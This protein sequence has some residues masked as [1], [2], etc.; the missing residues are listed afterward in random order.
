VIKLSIIARKTSPE[1][2]IY[3]PVYT[4]PPKNRSWRI[5]I[6][7]Y[8]TRS[9]CGSKLRISVRVLASYS[10]DIH[11]P[12][13]NRVQPTILCHYQKIYCALIY[14]W[15]YRNGSIY[16]RCNTQSRK[17][18]LA[19]KSRFGNNEADR[20]LVTVPLA[21]NREFH[22]FPFIRLINTLLQIRID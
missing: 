21:S 9:L 1:V 19:R 13:L 11:Q 20:E 3:V 16:T 22:P 2:V 8:T 7:Y 10:I 17:L 12:L 15:S 18:P 14:N 4:S 5:K 6:N